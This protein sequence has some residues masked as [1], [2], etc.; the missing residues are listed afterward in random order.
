MKIKQACV[1]A[2]TWELSDTL[3]EVLDVSDE[4]VEFFVGGHDLLPAI[5]AALTGLS[6]GDE[7]QL[8]LE[9]EQAFGDF[10][11]RLI[12][13]EERQHFPAAVEVGMLF[14]GLPQGCQSQA[15]VDL[16]YHV[17]DVYPQHVVVDGNHPLAGIALRLKLK[18][19]A[20]RAA[21]TEESDQG[22]LGVGFFQTAARGG[23][24]PQ[25]H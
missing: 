6:A 9:P 14:Q 4:A 24:P 17:T 7:K 2:L 5:E 11:E 19:H 8:Q 25:L 21:T 20:V 1:V 16:L 3:G 23:E 13:L 22:S 18:I 15:P 10:D 12:F